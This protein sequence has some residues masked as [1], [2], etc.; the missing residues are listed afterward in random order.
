MDRS[1][2]PVP[3]TM[4][5]FRTDRLVGRPR[6]VPQSSWTSAFIGSA[7]AVTGVDSIGRS[8]VAV[9]MASPNVL[10]LTL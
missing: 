9:F 4:L 5:A 3:A 7:G 6:A 1:R 2:Y 10:L 8:S